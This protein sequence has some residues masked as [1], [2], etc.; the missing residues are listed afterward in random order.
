[1]VLYFAEFSGKKLNVKSTKN[2]GCLPIFTRK[3]MGAEWVAAVIGIRKEIG[4]TVAPLALK[5]PPVS[6]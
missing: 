4:K 3:M 2:P 6:P 1:M 5:K